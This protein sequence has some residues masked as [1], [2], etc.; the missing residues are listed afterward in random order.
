MKVDDETIDNANVWVE[1]S[2]DN[3]NFKIDRIVVNMTADD[4]YYIPAG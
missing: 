3:T 4:D 2:D 1:G